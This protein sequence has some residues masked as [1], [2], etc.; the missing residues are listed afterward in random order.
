MDL[1]EK[2]KAVRVKTGLDQDEFSDEIGYSFSLYSKVEAGNKIASPGLLKAIKDRYGISDGYFDGNEK[3]V[4]TSMNK[5]K[6]SDN[7]YWENLIADYRLSRDKAIEDAKAWKQEMLD[8]K[9]QAQTL[10]KFLNAGKLNV[11]AYAGASK[12][13]QARTI[14]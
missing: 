1:K 12:K 13:A 8:W 6:K 10:S 4:I 5:V 11:L 7:G 14:Q 3:L 2:I 9:I